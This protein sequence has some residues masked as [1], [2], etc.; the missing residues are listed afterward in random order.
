MTSNCSSVRKPNKS[1]ELIKGD[2]QI[3]TRKT[4]FISLKAMWNKILYFFDLK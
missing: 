4:E 2:V 3:S 1:E